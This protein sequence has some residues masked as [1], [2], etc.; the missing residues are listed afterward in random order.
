MI[1]FFNDDLN[2]KKFKASNC[3][4]FKEAE[5]NKVI[6]ELYTDST[7]A[8]FPFYKQQVKFSSTQ[9]SDIK[10]LK[11]LETKNSKLKQC[12]PIET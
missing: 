10:Q 6:K 8:V 11:Q 12:F 3:F 5:A 4:L 1:L 7:M 9:S 2:I